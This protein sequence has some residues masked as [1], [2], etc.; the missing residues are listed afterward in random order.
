MGSNN[1]W[2]A[3]NLPSDLI[4]MLVVAEKSSKPDTE[5]E[6]DFTTLTIEVRSR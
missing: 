5:W 1:L 3:R 2:A 4:R 6:S